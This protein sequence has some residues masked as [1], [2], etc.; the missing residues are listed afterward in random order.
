MTE[1]A[2]SQI[3]GVLLI[4]GIL[5]DFLPYCNIERF[6]NISPIIG[7]FGRIAGLILIISKGVLIKTKYLFKITF[8]LLIFIF[9]SLMMKILLLPFAGFVF[10]I[11]IIGFWLIYNYHFYKK[12]RKGFL[13]IIKLVWLTI[14]LTAIIFKIHHYPFDNVLI[15]IA[16]IVFLVMYFYFLLN[17]LKCGNSPKICA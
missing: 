10:F 11:G 13:D 3:I 5:G 1:R 17:L 6:N 2:F 9:I 8:I 15:S 4:L 16:N 14:L 12:L 7:G